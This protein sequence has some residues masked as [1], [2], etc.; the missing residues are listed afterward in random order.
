VLD[1]ATGTLA[2]TRIPLS[3][4]IT[5][6]QGAGI[7]GGY[8]RLILYTGVATGMTTGTWYNVN[9]TS[10]MVT[11][12]GTSASPT[13]TACEN[14]AFWGIGEF[15]GGDYYAVFAQ[16]TTA[17]VRYRIRDAMTTTVAMF[18]GTGGLSDMCSLTFAP[19]TN[20]WYFHH[21]YNSSLGGM[22]SGETLGYCPATFDTP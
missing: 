21:E 11:M 17:I 18:P 14:W 7:F 10:G 8:S 19:T 13:H 16:S 20:R 1:G 4:P 3:T 9:P 12:L 6:A 22:A 2:A 15:F 5:F